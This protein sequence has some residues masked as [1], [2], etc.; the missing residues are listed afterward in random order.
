MT[1]S[2]PDRRVVGLDVGGTMIK[3]VLVGADGQPLLT[4]QRPTHADLGAGQVVDGIVSYAREFSQICAER[5]GRA[6]DALGLAVPGTVN[7]EAG[8]A[9]YSANIGWRDLPLRDI[10]ANSVGVAVALTHD[11]RAGA[12]AEA[13][14]GAARG[15]RRSLF[16]PL[17]TGVAA[18]LVIDGVPYHG[19]HWSGGELGHVVVRPQ[20]RACRCGSQGC[21]ETVSSAAAIARS[22]VAVGGSAISA[23]EIAALAAA[24]DT[25]AAG[26]WGDAVDALATGLLMCLALIDPDVIVV[27]GGLAAA[28]ETL[29]APLRRALAAQASYH[30]VP[31]IVPAALGALAGAVGAALVARDALQ[32]N[33]EKG[34]EKEKPCHC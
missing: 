16:V 9:A 17:G 25:A 12:L 27:G 28:G 32:T 22:Y 21:L 29:L 24:G 18:A 13:R 8:V 19:G 4:D 11:V 26:V 3:A 34:Q 20:G 31:P 10:V 30:V 33:P 15:Y 1:T 2:A 14:L 5:S 23:E 6:I 7:D